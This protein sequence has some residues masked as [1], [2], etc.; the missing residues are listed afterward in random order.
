MF[1][2]FTRVHHVCY[3]PIK[4]LFRVQKLQHKPLALNDSVAVTNLIVVVR[5]F[6]PLILTELH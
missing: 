3:K 6:T 5:D 1:E 4:C 2:P